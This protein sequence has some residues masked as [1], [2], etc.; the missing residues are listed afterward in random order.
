MLACASLPGAYNLH[1]SSN[2]KSLKVDSAVHFFHAIQGL[3]SSSYT[4]HI[5]TGLSVTSDLFIL[6]VSPI[7][8]LFFFDSKIYP[9]FSW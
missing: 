4:L 1:D 3:F 9:P 2:Y 5:I 8:F 6:F 7:F